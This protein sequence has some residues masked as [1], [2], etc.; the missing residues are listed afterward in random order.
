MPTKRRTPSVTGQGVARVE[1]EV[2]KAVLNEYVAYL[3]HPIRVFSANFLAGLA[4]GVGFALGA[5]VLVAL[6]V[7]LLA[8]MG[9][10]PYVGEWFRW[11]AERLATEVPR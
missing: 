1:A 8:W 5:T 2:L 7:T 10:F 9:T 3:R 4:R 6:L 11:M